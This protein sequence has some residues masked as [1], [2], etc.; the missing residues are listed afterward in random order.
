MISV[1]APFPL[2]HAAWLNSLCAADNLLVIQDL[3]GVC[4]GLVQDPLTRTL[5][6]RYIEAAGRM[7]GHFY[8]LTNGEH[9]GSRGVNAIVERAFDTAGYPAEH[10]L[11]LPGLAA[12]GVQLQDCHGRVTH[13]GV[14]DAELRFL[15]ALPARFAAYLDDRLAKLSPE[16]SSAERDVLTRACVLD[17]RVSPTLNI[18]AC[19]ARLAKDPE[20]YVRLQHELER[21]MRSLL[22]EAAASGLHDAFFIHYAPNLG[23]D[24]HGGERL[25]P[26]NA[27]D[28][29]TT[30]FQFMLNGAIKEVGV[31]VILNHYYQACTGQY[32]L[33]EHFNARQAP[34]DLAALL[35]LARERLDPAYMPRI[36]AV[37]DTVTSQI[38]AADPNRAPLRG[39]SDRGFLTLVQQLGDAFQI[40]NVVA[41]IDSSGDEVRR[42]GIDAD[43]LRACQIDRALVPWPALDGISDPSDPL[44]L[45]VIFDGGYRQ[46]S[47]FF[48][49]LAGCRC[50]R[51]TPLR[52]PTLE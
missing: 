35:T 38:D 4:M 14:S 48:E 16:L 28:A 26:G 27:D 39:G 7:R 43:H 42:P 33:G 49:A 30:D 52:R 19:Y 45:D 51:A 5:D 13:P 21:Y 10:G 1:P 15:E 3:D 40:D 46:Y 6:R 18:N 44:R 34:Q 12:G 23:R 32:P 41:Y 47:A 11:Y 20:V 37:G 17:N 50:R 29:G 36:L 8:V 25:R 2:N 9:I 31:L 24:A 22:E